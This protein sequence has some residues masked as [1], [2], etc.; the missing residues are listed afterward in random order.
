MLMKRIKNG[1]P[2]IGRRDHGRPH[3][4]DHTFALVWCGVGNLCGLFSRK[5]I[6]VI[7]IKVALCRNRVLKVF[8]V[9]LE[10]EIFQIVK[11]ARILLLYSYRRHFRST[12]DKNRTSV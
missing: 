10:C 12:Y 1:R 7:H 5:P 8:S 9:S 2:Q 11:A 3:V 6:R 4:K